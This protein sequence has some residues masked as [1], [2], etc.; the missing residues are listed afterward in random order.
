ML[1]PGA[2]GKLSPEDTQW[3]L[4]AGHPWMAAR[5]C[6]WVSFLTKPE[7][8]LSRRPSFLDLLDPTC[9]HLPQ[10]RW[11]APGRGDPCLGSAVHF[12]I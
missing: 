6:A 2:G 9:P 3:I 4:W 1:G 5:G 12:R 8:G 7:P 10:R 11:R